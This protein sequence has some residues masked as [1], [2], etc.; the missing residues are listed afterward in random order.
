MAVTGPGQL[1]RGAELLQGVLADGLQQPVAGRGGIAVVRLNERFLNHRC[2]QV[3]DLLA[4]KPL[5]RA[6]LFCRVEGEP[7]GEHRQAAEQHA[8]IG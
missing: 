7:A 8:L 6:H 1:A 2:Q 4:F 5:A 3:K